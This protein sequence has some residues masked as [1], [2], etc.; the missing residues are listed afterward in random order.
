MLFLPLKVRQ[1]MAATEATT[2]KSAIVM[3]MLDI[4]VPTVALVTMEVTT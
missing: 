1:A 3:A 2:A 4:V